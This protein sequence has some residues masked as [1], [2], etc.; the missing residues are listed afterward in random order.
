MNNN[1]LRELS[2]T[3][4]AKELNKNTQEIFQQLS[5]MRLVSRNGEG[6]DLTEIGKAKGGSYKTIDKDGKHIKYIVWPESIISDFEDSIEPSAHPLTATSI[7]KGFGLPA[8]RV[9]SILSELGWIKKDPVNGWQITELG[10]K[11][12]GTQAK[13]K[14]GVPYVRWPNTV[15]TNKILVVSINESKGEILSSSQD[16]QEDNS[17]EAKEFREKFPAKNRTKDGHF[18]R[19]KAETI[20]DNWIY[21]AKI[22]HAYERKV[23]VEEELYCDF[24]IPT[25]KVYIEYWG[26]EDQDYLR[27]REKKLSI[28]SKHD[29]NLIQL[30]DR[31]VSNIDDVLPAKLREF[32]VIPED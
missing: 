14:T 16:Q 19:S 21:E 12:G 7:G 26:L 5:E 17:S 3:S 10:K 6:W 24:W 20:I 4:L 18:V 30:T 23:P 29:L 1:K 11:I 27:R 31:D 13:Y 28:Y 8:S 2:A 32:G 9:N 25:G 22:V 15:M